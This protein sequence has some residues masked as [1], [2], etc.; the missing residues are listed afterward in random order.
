MGWDSAGLLQHSWLIRITLDS[1]FLMTDNLEENDFMK[2]WSKVLQGHL[3]VACFFLF[4]C[5]F[6]KKGGSGTA[7]G[8]NV[9]TVGD[10]FEGRSG[11]LPLAR[12]LG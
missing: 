4:A 3:G 10:G 12:N 1:H 11:N 9:L 6:L 7:Q 5:L 8:S 2:F